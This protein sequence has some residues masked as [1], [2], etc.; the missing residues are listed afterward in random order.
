MKKATHLFVIFLLMMT[1]VFVSCRE[2]KF[3]NQEKTK[4]EATQ[5][6]ELEVTDEPAL[7]VLNQIVDNEEKYPRADLNIFADEEISVRLKNILGEDYDQVVENFNTET[8]IVSEGKIY[9]FTGCKEHDCPAF[10]TTVLYDAESDNLNVLIEEN[11]KTRVFDE[12]GKIK[13]SKALLR[14]K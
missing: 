14:T 7:K 4:I 9:K 8:P 2:N 11:G 6:G 1:V 3:E 13:A 10:F 12:D 5:S